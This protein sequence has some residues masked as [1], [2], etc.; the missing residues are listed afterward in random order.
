[1]FRR[2]PADLSD[3]QQRMLDSILALNA[4]INT[5]YLLKEQ[6]RQVYWLPYKQALA[7]FDAWL[8]CARDCQLAPFVRL[9]ER[10]AQQRA[11]IEAA[12]FYR[13]SNARVE[14]INSQLRQIIN[15]SFGFRS[16]NAVIAAAMLSLGGLCP[17]P[18]RDQ[19]RDLPQTLSRLAIMQAR[20]GKPRQVSGPFRAMS[21][22]SE[23][24]H[25]SGARSEC[26]G[27]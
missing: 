17:P 22:K 8:A 27:S 20:A 6:L 26:Y 25:R 1:V 2:K 21:K 7:L 10:L 5:A 11:K 12:L 4:P 9:A 24:D 14:Q 15:R 3:G 23:T 13:F 18:P 19:L 16:A